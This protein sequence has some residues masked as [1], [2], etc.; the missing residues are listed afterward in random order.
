MS[1]GKEAGNVQGIATTVAAQWLPVG[2]LRQ[3]DRNPRVNAQAI[4]AVAESIRRFGFVSPIVVWSSAN[5]MVAGHTRLKAMAQLLAEDPGFTAKGAPGPG[6]CRVVFQEFA[7]EAEANA[8]ALADNRL[9]EIADWEDGGL[10][11]VVSELAAED[12][13]LIA[14]AGFTDNEVNALLS[15]RG[16]ND[17]EAEYIGMPE[18]DSEDLTAKFSVKVNFANEDDVAAFGALVGQTV[19]TTTKSLWFPEAE[20]GRYADKAYEDEGAV[21]GAN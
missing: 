1:Q 7:S 12:A 13:A 20:I 16:E 17:V 5:R 8:F 18:C 4:P 11:E 14:A 9:A 21:E 15:E 2:D 6:L 19:L 10:R 3:W